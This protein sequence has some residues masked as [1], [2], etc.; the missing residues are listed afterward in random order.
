MATKQEKEDGVV[1]RPDLEVVKGKGVNEEVGAVTD[2]SPIAKAD[3]TSYPVP[4]DAEL[5]QPP[6]RS[7]KAPVDLAVSLAEGAGQHQPPD[8]KLYDAEGRPRP[9]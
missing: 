8:P 2:P 5:H 9:E 7:P 3:E 4:N 6:L 1:D